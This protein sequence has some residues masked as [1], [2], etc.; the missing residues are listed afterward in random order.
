VPLNRWLRERL[1]PW[2]EE[3]LT[4]SRLRRDGFFD[5]AVVRRLWGEHL[6]GRRRWEGA[7]WRILM[8]QAWLGAQS[9]VA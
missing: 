4:E 6:A 2:A 8:F 5:A 9:A 3:L 1:R 7:L